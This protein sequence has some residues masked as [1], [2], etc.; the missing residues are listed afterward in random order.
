M[1]LLLL[2]P[3]Q[4]TP[5]MAA[6]K[7]QR[8]PE[9]LHSRRQQLQRQSGPS[10]QLRSRLQQ[11]QQPGSKILM[12]GR[13]CPTCW[14]CCPLMTMMMRVTSLLLA[15]LLLLLLLHSMLPCTRH[16]QQQPVMLLKVLLLLTAC[17]APGPAA[18]KG[19]GGSRVAA[20]PAAQQRTGQSKAA[21]WSCQMM[22]SDT[23]QTSSSY[24]GNSSSNALSP[25]S[26]K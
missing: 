7:Q 13:R 2:L 9:V 22:G 14:E 24:S 5:T 23:S 16:H 17:G 21:S 20:A 15:L 12:C 6:M 26:S 11:Q 19:S 18:N 8:E 1:H 3:L 25:G 10:R 4:L